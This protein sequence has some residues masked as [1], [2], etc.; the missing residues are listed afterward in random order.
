[1]SKF[2]AF[3]GES[4]QTTLKA[5]RSKE[6][7]CFSTPLTVDPKLEFKGHN[8]FTSPLGSTTQTSQIK[9]FKPKDNSFFIIGGIPLEEA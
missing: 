4:C 8:H 9:Q 2:P 5:N 3:A 7:G 1:M 6:K